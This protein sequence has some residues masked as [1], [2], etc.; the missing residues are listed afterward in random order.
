MTMP[1]G[2]MLLPEFDQEMAI[3]RRVLERVPDEKAEW[4]PHPKSFAFGHLAQ[5][6]SWMPGW[7]ANTLREPGLDLAKAGGYS[8]EPTATLL[9]S[10]DENV[11]AA[12]AALRE[13][14]DDAWAETWSLTRGGQTLWKAPRGVVVRNHL[15]HLIHHRAQ[16]TVYLRLNDV[17]VPATYGP[18]ADERT[19]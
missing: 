1:I 11:A 9:R 16:L 8:F 12:R 10:F 19:F 4:K 17:P 3:T 18:S 14:P 6:V 7:I 13:T 2:D 5:L 15:N